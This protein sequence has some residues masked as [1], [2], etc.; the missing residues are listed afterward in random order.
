MDS[1][2]SS[3]GATTTTESVAESVEPE[4]RKR[5]SLVNWKRSLKTV[6]KN[7]DKLSL[8]PFSLKSMPSNVT[9]TIQL[10]L[11]LAMTCNKSSFNLN[12]SDF[13]CSNLITLQ[14][15]DVV[16]ASYPRSGGQIV[17]HILYKLIVSCYS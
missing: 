6:T 10:Y 1:P 5:E 15:A 12:A 9:I 11:L 8:D 2:V 4:P 13:N 14:S 7:I 17:C 16:V 3:T